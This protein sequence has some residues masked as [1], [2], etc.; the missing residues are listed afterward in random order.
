MHVRPK[1]RLPSFATARILRLPFR[2]HLRTQFLTVCPEWVRQHPT[3]FHS[4]DRAHSSFSNKAAMSSANVI[5]ELRT[6]TFV[7]RAAFGEVV[8]RETSSDL[9]PKPESLRADAEQR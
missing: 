7:T 4:V 1:Y 8:P 2:S 6:N 5:F 9:G 3:A